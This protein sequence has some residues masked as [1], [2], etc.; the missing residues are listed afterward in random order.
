MR[1]LT[2]FQI[3]DFLDTLASLTT[4]F[5]LGTLIGAEPRAFGPTCWSR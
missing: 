2:T 3:Y 4:A 5:V 1:F